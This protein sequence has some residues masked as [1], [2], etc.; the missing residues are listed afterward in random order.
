MGEID[1]DPD[2]D[3]D[4]AKRHGGFQK[5]LDPLERL[6]RPGFQNSPDIIRVIFMQVRVC[7][8]QLNPT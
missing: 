6:I 2:F 4:Y 1:F 7:W 5:D 8:L 3:L